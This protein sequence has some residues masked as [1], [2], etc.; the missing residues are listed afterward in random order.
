MRF[1]QSWLAVGAIVVSMAL[2]TSGWA[3]SSLDARMERLERL[4][5]SQ[6]SVDTFN[7]LESLQQELRELRG[8]LEEQEH[9]LQLLNT[10]QEQLYADL[11]DRLGQLSKAKQNSTQQAQVIPQSSTA[12]VSPIS[13]TKLKTKQDEE[14]AVYE[15]AYQLM[16]SRKYPQAVTAF[17]DFL[18]QYPEGQY[19]PNAH[20]W[21]GEIYLVQ[22]NQNRENLQYVEQ[23]VQSFQTVIT[24]YKEHQKGVDALLKLGL[25]EVDKE[26][27]TA[28]KTLLTQLKNEYPDSS[29]ARIAEAKLQRLKQEGRI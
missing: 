27:W 12:Q 28:A 18:W 9:A 14:K 3:R 24:K 26:N 2:P 11:D 29:R 23:A 15:A 20:Y 19:V 25:I 1:T 17:Q 13:A 7:Q 10:R 5:E 4:V 21:L 6:L 8:Q 16:D 22:W